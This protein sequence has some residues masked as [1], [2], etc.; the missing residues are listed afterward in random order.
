MARSSKP[1]Y[2]EGFVEMLYIQY[3]AAIYSVI[4]R[5]IEKTSERED[6]FHDVFVRILH[7]AEFLSTLP[8]HK[9]E[10]YLLLMAR[11]VTIDYLRK[12][13]FYH[14]SD[15][16]DDIITELLHARKLRASD[17]VEQTDKIELSMMLQCI[18]AEDVAL[19]IGRY[20]LNLDTKELAEMCDITPTAVRSR[21]HRARKRLLEAWKETGLSMGDFIDG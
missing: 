8:Q 7:K 16:P 12:N 13:D 9:L 11:G 1:Q 5:Y 10:T 20:Y 4:A 15:L 19:L 3:K 18:P 2:P 14:R 6:V 21:V 17:R